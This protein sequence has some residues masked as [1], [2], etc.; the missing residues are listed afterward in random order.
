MNNSKKA[1]A[2]LIDLNKAFDRVDNFTLIK[3]LQDLNITGNIYRYIYNFLSNHTATIMIKNKL[4]Q[5]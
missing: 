3:K 5:I 1:V 4:R 2:I